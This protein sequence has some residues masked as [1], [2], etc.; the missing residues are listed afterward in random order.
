MQSFTDSPIYQKAFEQ[1]LRKGTSIEVSIKRMLKAE[2]A[3]NHHT[4]RY[5]WLT[6]G[7]E[8]VRPSHAA[9]D[10]KIFYWSDP[11]PTGHP[12]EDFNCRCVAVPYVDMQDAALFAVGSMV[13][14]TPLN[15][16]RVLASRVLR[17]GIR[18]IVRREEAPPEQKPSEPTPLP[19]P[20]GIPKHWQKMPSKKGEGVRY[21]DPK[22]PKYN[23]VRIQRGDPASSNSGQRQ[24][25]VTWKKD[26]HY[27]DK[28]GK[29]V[30][31]KSLDAHI[32]IEEFRFNPEIFK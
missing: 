14:I 31:R 25:Y 1:Y 18:R 4:P 3:T 13:A 2:T 8:K 32:P 12:A 26:G 19:K 20:E 29:R 5:M 22:N 6:S 27:L 15:R 21:V 30:P 16:G 23:E 7:D 9:N 28:Y 24:D 10:G 17:E 11:P